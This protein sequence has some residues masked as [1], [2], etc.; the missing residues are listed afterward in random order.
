MY[1]CQP[2]G[3]QYLSLC[4]HIPAWFAVFQIPHD[5]VVDVLHMNTDLM[6]PSC[7]QPAFHIG[8]VLEALQYMEMGAGFTRRLICHFHFL[9]V[10]GITS[11]RCVDQS[12]IMH[13]VAHDDSQVVPSACL[14][15]KLCGDRCMSKVILAGND[16]SGRIFIDP[17]DDAGT[18][19][20]VDA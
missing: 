19:H 17:V 2:V 15:F 18:D 4:V 11:D 3:M 5:R 10:S 20:T 12:V 8:A 7:I 6:G 14:A 9:P 13:D 1:E 16:A